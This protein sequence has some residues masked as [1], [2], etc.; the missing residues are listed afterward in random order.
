[1]CHVK[2]LNHFVIDKIKLQADQVISLVESRNLVDTKIFPAWHCKPD[3]RFFNHYTI[4]SYEV[5]IT[6]QNSYFLQ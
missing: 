4:G 5:Y 1:M 6:L 3:V 2:C